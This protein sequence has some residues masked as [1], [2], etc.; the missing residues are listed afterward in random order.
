MHL[1]SF[2]DS[3]LHAQLWYESQKCKRPSSTVLVLGS[4]LPLQFPKRPSCP[5]RSAPRT[6]PAQSCS[7]L[8]SWIFSHSLSCFSTATLHCGVHDAQTG[9]GGMPEE[10][11]CQEETQG[12]Q[13][14]KRHTHTQCR[15]SYWRKW[16]LQIKCNPSFLSIK[17][18]FSHIHVHIHMWPLLAPTAVDM[19]SFQLSIQTFKS[20]LCCFWFIHTTATLQHLAP[21]VVGEKEERKRGRRFGK[22][23]SLVQSV[24]QFW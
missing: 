9:D 8:W 23:C 10:V 12:A 1:L 15:N 16:V 3:N 4:L 13:N 19:T 6:A 5:G 21:R 22:L 7:F 11:Q 24:D 18:L 17:T 2:K 14:G 20:R